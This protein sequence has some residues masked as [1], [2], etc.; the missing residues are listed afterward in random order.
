MKKAIIVLLMVLCCMALFACEKQCEHQYQ[1]AVTTEASC[2]VVGVKTFT[3]SL[4]QDTYVEEIPVIEHNYESILTQ[5]ATCSEKGVTTFTCAECGDTYT[6]DIEMAAHSLNDVVVTKEPTCSE[7]GERT[8]NCA[9]CGATGLKEAIPAI[10]HLYETTTTKLPTCTEQGEKTHT[11]K[12]CG[13]SNTTSMAAVGH[14]YSQRTIT[15]KAT[16]IADGKETYTCIN[17]NDSY[18]NNIPVF[19]HDYASKT[20]TPA[21]CTHTGVITVKCSRCDSSYPET[22]P[23]T[24]HNWIVATCVK[25]KHCSACG[26]TSGDPLPH[27]NVID[28][29]VAAKCEKNGLTEGSHCADC[30]TVWQTQSVIP[31]TGHDWQPHSIFYNEPG[32]MY[33]YV[34][35]YDCKKC[36]TRKEIEDFPIAHTT[37]DSRC[38]KCD[39]IITTLTNGDCT[40]TY[41]ANTVKTCYYS[42]GKYSYTNAKPFCELK[43][44]EASGTVK[45]RVSISYKRVEGAYLW[46]E[47]FLFNENGDRIFIGNKLHTDQYGNQFVTYG[48][49]TTVTLP[50][51]NWKLVIDNKNNA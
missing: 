46:F 34:N 8:F 26:Q 42:A 17:C 25:A 50:A 21:S 31:A 4:C 20:T 16:C 15:Q 45:L 40:L 7:E 19:G 30:G 48:F 1:E 13:S 24:D 22:I 3:C 28:S 51:G 11:C 27:N 38:E 35:T 2:S 10:E 9:S 32:C 18:S 49:E 5:D 37:S 14:N 29:A 12:V 41:T 43:Y 6:E 23:V 39:N 33:S 44:D 36:Y 47:A